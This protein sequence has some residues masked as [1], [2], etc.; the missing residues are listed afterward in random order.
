MLPSRSNLIFYA[1][2]TL[3]LLVAAFPALVVMP[4]SAALRAIT[5]E[6]DFFEVKALW[7]WAGTLWALLTISLVRSVL[8]LRQRGRASM[9]QR[10]YLALAVLQLSATALVSLWL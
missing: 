9:A 2:A 4:S 3:G 8:V 10:W 7:V 1:L 5:G 6:V